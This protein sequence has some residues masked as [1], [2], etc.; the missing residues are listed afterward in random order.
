M[1]SPKVASTASSGGS[2]VARKQYVPFLA[3]GKEERSSEMVYIERS[4]RNILAILL[5]NLNKICVLCD[6]VQ[7]THY[8]K[9]KT[10]AVV[11]G[12]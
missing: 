9:L 5:F 11:F 7:F 8:G 4:T 3:K 2:S 12:Y 6:H 1:R 10:K